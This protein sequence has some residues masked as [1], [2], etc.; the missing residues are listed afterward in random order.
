MS[1]LDKLTCSE[2]CLTCT[3]YLFRLM[4]QGY[5]DPQELKGPEP[6]KDLPLW[7]WPN[8]HL[9]SSNYTLSSIIFYG[10]WLERTAYRRYFLL[11]L[12]Q[13]LASDSQ[14][15]QAIVYVNGSASAEHICSWL[16]SEGI[17]ANFVVSEQYIKFFL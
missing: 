15:N 12:L 2:A 1:T 9:T 4:P 7:P 17:S 14:N 13:L 11:K 5:L 3:E 6:P 8:E 16:Q 10:V